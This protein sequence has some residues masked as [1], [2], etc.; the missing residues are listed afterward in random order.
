[1]VD[2]GDE[3]KMLTLHTVRSG[4][5]LSDGQLPVRCGQYHGYLVIPKN[6]YLNLAG[7]GDLTRPSIGHEHKLVIR[8]TDSLSLYRNK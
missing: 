5:L 8:F 1:M 2:D 6:W 3:K 4:S 7:A